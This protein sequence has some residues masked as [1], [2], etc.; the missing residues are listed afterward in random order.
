MPA[1]KKLPLAAA[2][3]KPGK[4]AAASGPGA[5]DTFKYK[6]T[7]EDAEALAAELIPDNI[8]ANLSDSAWKVRLAALEEMTTWVEDNVNDLDS[9]VIVRA[10][11]KKGWSESNFQVRLTL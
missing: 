10:L 7:P 9:E 5:L 8:A 2:A 4:G 6:H 1:V 11:G 3:S